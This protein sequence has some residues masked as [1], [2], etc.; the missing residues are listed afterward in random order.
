MW[1]LMCAECLLLHCY[2]VVKCCLLQK[3]PL[4][5]LYDMLVSRFG[6][7]SGYVNFLACH[8]PGQSLIAHLSY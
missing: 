3:R 2:A 4:S 1:L 7:G 5:S 6:S 8:L